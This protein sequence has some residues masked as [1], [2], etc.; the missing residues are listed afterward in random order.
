MP[1]AGRGSDGDIL[2][3]R[4]C[5]GAEIPAARLQPLEHINDLTLRTVFS[6]RRSGLRSVTADVGCSRFSSY[7]LVPRAC[8]ALHGADRE[9]RALLAADRDGDGTE[10]REGPLQSQRA[11]AD[12]APVSW[13]PGR[14][15]R[16]PAPRADGIRPS[17]TS[18]GSRVAA[19]RTRYLVLRR[20]G[21]N[22]YSSCVA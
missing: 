5:H 21:T 12:S 15:W 17:K 7:T 13:W 11:R 6:V 18:L 20:S 16:R 3:R 1:I 9:D 2:R 19:P 10:S 14:N 8:N 4:P 22:R